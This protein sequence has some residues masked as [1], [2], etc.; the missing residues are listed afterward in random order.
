[1][2]GIQVPGSGKPIIL[3]SDRQTTGGYTKIATVIGPDIGI[4]AQCRPGDGVRFRAVSMAEAQR[5]ARELEAALG[6][7]PAMLSREI[8]EERYHG[9]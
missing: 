7:L 6:G 3:L 1:M 8:L 5:A 9:C 2:G 4:L